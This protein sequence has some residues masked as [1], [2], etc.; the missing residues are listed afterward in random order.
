MDSKASSKLSAAR[1]KE[2]NMPSFLKEDA[3]LGLIERIAG[4][5]YR[6]IFTLALIEPQ[7][8]GMDC[9][10]ISDSGSKILIEATSG[11]AASSAFRWYLEERCNSY[12]GPLTRRLAFPEVPPKVGE[13]HADSSQCLYRYFLN[14]CTFGYTLVYWQWDEWQ[15]LLDWMMLAGYNLVLNPMA[16]ELVW[17]NLLQKLGYT[18]EE[19]RRFPAAPTFYPWQGMMN[20]TSW[21][22]AAPQ[23]WYEA[24]LQ[25]ARQINERM[26]DFGCA[27]L[28]PGYSGMVPN[29]F[30]E[31]FPESKPF[32]QGLW[33]GMARP[34][35]LLPDDVCFDRVAS[36]F[37]QTQRELLGDTFNYFSTDPF[38]EGGDSSLVDLPSYAQKCLNHMKAV[39]D[40]P[41]WFLQGWQNNPLRDML[42]AMPTENVLVGNLRSTDKADGGDDFADYP[43]LYCCVNNFGGQRVLRG[44]MN[45][46][47][48]EAYQMLTAADHTCVGI[49]IIPE[50]IEDNEILYDVF[51]DVAIRHDAID[52]ES[53][54]RN[55]IKIRYGVVTPELEQAWDIIRNELLVY[56]TEKNPKE[57]ALCT[58]P[59]L[60]VD[61]V[62]VYSGNRFPFDY[63]KAEEAL[64]LMMT[65]Q[66]DLLQSETGTL[67]LM[68]LARAVV[69]N[70]AWVYLVGIQR[71]YKFGEADTLEKNAEEFMKCYDVQEKVVA[72]DKHMMLGPWLERA[73]A[74]GKTMAEKAYFEFT[75]RTLVTLWGDRGGAEELRDYAAKE[76]DGLLHDFYRP[77]WESYLNILRRSMLTGEKPM[78]YNR[79]DAEYL[80]TTL[81]T[82]YPTEP[83]GN[84]KEALQ[85]VVALL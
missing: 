30:S 26:Q 58:R 83:Y 11:V 7:E 64:R 61:K 8:T 65:A 72:C 76:W 42:R 35:I 24:R 54:M 20:L 4:K 17:I 21:G 68:D 75:A 12:V 71:A 2:K 56:D 19:A 28:L 70:R 80:F 1:A 57:S 38:H 66:D 81:S 9:F 49:G 41:I 29:D 48:T 62:C 55:R 14:Y 69:A 31:H 40:H 73:K 18:E 46:M 39:S 37:Y 22:S 15:K 85:A 74:N 16:N 6:D 32:N 45:K 77:R 84:A 5:T 59:S 3:V 10:R 13:P 44:N 79:Y 60:T 63:K 82:C 78:E 34:S 51:A 67:D 50:G 33:C 52:P 47:M 27:V 25:L 53:W 43:W 36:A 23:E